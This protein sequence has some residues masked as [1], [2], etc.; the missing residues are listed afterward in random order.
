M[1]NFLSGGKDVVVR[2][3]LTEPWKQQM[4]DRTAQRLG[5]TDGRI[6]RQQFL[7]GM[8]RQGGQGGPGAAPN[9]GDID[10]RAE[11]QFRRRD[12]N[13]DGLLNSDEMPE[14]LRAERDKWDTNKDGFIDL[15]EFKVYFRAR[16][17][18]RMAGRGANG[19]AGPAAVITAESPEEEEDKK[20]VVYRVGKLPKE[21]PGWFEQI[22]TDK[23]AQIGLYEWRQAGRSIEEFQR[24]DR[25][26]DGFLTVE[27]VLRYEKLNKNGG[28]G[29]A[30][31]AG[32]TDRT[33]F[34]NGPGGPPPNGGNGRR[35]N[36]NRNQ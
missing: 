15:A 29:V 33:S 20:P 17:E 21:L 35:R 12:Q 23:D 30:A 22:D 9:G 11:E 31:R 36:F 5:I 6:T 1:F 25:N 4:F 10:A 16:M 18:Q 3:E 19:E 32:P 7:D 26:G 8:N 28:D 2:S 34:M 24:I 13:G 27:E 14:D